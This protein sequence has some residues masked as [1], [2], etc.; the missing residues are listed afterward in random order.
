MYI[1]VQFD[2][3]MNYGTVLRLQFVFILKEKK[4]NKVIYFLYPRQSHVLSLYPT[5]NI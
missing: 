4:Q 3:F 1:K 5:N 2:I